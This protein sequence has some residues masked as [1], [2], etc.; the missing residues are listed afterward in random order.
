MAKKQYRYPLAGPYNTRVVSSLPG[1]SGIV[2]AGIVGVMIVGKTAQTSNKDRRFINVW[3]ETVVNQAN[4]TKTMYLVKRPGFALSATPQAG[5]IGNALLVWSGQGAGTKVISAFGATNS[6]IYDGETQLVTNHSN[7]AIITG[8]ATG[9]TETSIS[10]T[11]TIAITSSDNTA[12]Y[13][14]DAGTV[15]KITDADFPGNNSLTLAGTFAHMDGYAFIMDTTGNIYNSDVNSLT[16]WAAS[17][18]IPCNSY[19]DLGVGCI[20]R[21]NNIIGFGTQTIQF[22]RN[23]GNAFGS[24]LQRIEE[25]TLKIG[26]VGANAIATIGD[27][28]YWTGSTPEGG[29]SVYKMSDGVK[30]I[31]TP[32]INRILQLAGASNI[33][34]TSAKIYGR[35]FVILNA[36]TLTF[37]YCEEEGLWH[38]WTSSQGVLWNKCAGVST[39]SSQVTYAISNTLT[40]GKVYVINPTSYVFTDDSQPYTATAQSALIGDGNVRTFWR[41]M[42]LLADQE[43]SSSPM[44]VHVSDDDYESSTLLGTVDLSMARPRLTACGSAYRRSWVFTHSAATSFRIEAMLGTIEEGSH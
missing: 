5:S 42:T 10:S 26:C 40:G 31:S 33:T 24:V 18:L 38:E 9:I 4:N 34:M 44:S 1:S 3:S 32:E 23:A 27:S 41:D 35:S 25:M 13:Y 39:G 29:I 36:S 6:S 2:G 43:G 19:P 20:R 28:I 22:F 8:K 37:V 11:P 17:S 15:T 30:P 21:G 14:Q 16:S 12:W 7:T